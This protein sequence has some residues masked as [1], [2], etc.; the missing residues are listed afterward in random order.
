MSEKWVKQSLDLKGKKNNFY[1]YQWWHTLDRDENNKVT[2]ANDFYADGLLG[3]F[4]YVYPKKNIVM[5]R[6]GKTEGPGGWPTL[7]KAIARAN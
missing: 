4:I 7:M 2:P 5:V 6:L 1:S 3:Q